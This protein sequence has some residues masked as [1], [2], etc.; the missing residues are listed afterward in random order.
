MLFTNNPDLRDI[1][2]K[3][4]R[5]FESCYEL[6]VFGRFDDEKLQNIR[7]GHVIKGVKM[8]PFFVS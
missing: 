4:E 5:L 1:I 2:V 7:R 8:G 6:K 3:N